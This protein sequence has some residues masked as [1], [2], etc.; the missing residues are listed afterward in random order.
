MRQRERESDMLIL[1]KSIACATGCLPTQHND[2]NQ[3]LTLSWLKP[4]SEHSKLGQPHEIQSAYHCFSDKGADMFSPEITA[5]TDKT[6]LHHS[7]VQD[8]HHPC[9]PPPPRKRKHIYI[10]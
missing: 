4:Q 3:L 9:M 1:G 6:E 5:T 2:Q 7:K 8:Q 10:L